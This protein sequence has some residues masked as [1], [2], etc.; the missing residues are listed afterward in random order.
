MPATDRSPTRTESRPRSN[1]PRALRRHDPIPSGDLAGFDDPVFIEVVSRDVRRALDADRAAELRAAP[2]RDRW[3]AALELLLGDVEAQI[4][5]GT[6]SEQW[7]SKA[8]GF[9]RALQRCLAEATG[10]PDSTGPAAAASAHPRSSPR[11]RP[12]LVR[13]RSTE[14]ASTL[15]R[16]VRELEGLIAAHRDHGCC[17]ACDDSCPAD[18]ELWAAI[19]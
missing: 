16:R 2:L 7:R 18:E 17:D 9:R 13:D 10:S 6:G 14:T 15:E 4:A 5:A 12:S 3:V 11:A 1:V 8:R 19:T